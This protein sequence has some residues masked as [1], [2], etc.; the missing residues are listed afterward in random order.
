MKKINRELKEKNIAKK[1]KLKQDLKQ[2]SKKG[3]D[4]IEGETDK[5]IEALDFYNGLFF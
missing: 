2:F 5:K 3:K 4:T 1:E